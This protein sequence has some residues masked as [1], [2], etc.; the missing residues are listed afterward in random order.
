MCRGVMLG[1]TVTKI[2]A[3]RTPLNEELSTKSAIL[4]P[5]KAYVNGFGYFLFHGVIGKTC[6][7]GVVY[8]EWGRRLGVYELGEGGANGNVLLAIDKSGVN[9]GFGGGGHKIGQNFGKGEDGA[10]DGGFTRRG[11]VSN[12]GTIAK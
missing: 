3:T 2:G 11:L 5:I 7:S 9:F 10:I 12:M 8:T 6:G 1:E 4:N